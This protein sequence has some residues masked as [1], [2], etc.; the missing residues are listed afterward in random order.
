MCIRDR[1]DWER[2]RIRRY[3]NQDQ[4]QKFSGDKGLEF[5]QELQEKE[6]F[7]GVVK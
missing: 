6:L 5:I 7:W 1:I 2:S 4:Q 3:T